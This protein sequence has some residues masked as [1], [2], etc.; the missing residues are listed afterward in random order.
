MKNT[1]LSLLAALMLASLSASAQVAECTAPVVDRASVLSSADIA[2]LTTATQQLAHEGADPRVITYTGSDTPETVLAKDTQLC[3]AWKN[4]SNGVKSNMIVFMVNPGLRKMAIFSGSAYNDTALSVAAT[5][6]IKRNFMGPSFRDGQWAQG[7]LAGLQQSTQRIHGFVSNAGKS[8]TTVINETPTDFSGLWLFLKLL[9]GACLLGLGGFGMVRYFGFRGRRN[10]AQL[11]AIT[12]F[13]TLTTNL[14]RLSD[15]INE[16]TA[17]GKKISNIDRA[18]S[19]I[20]EEYSSL[21]TSESL[22]PN[23][24]GLTIEQYESIAARY[25]DM[26]RTVQ[27][28]QQGDTSTMGQAVVPNHNHNKWP[29][30]SKKGLEKTAT[31]ST[32]PSP[33]AKTVTHAEDEPVHKYPKPDIYPR[34]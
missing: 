18:Y 13:N 24:K 26:N 20:A 3:S 23:E 33:S 27:K 2:Q 32:T 5:S 25:A 12:A 22:N 15:Y 16:Q 10:L 6:D 7:L 30:F 34:M 21:A 9:L 1:F 4:P 28:L 17:L 29:K 8:N 11:N 31:T 19:L 14:N